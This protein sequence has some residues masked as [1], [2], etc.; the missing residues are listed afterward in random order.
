MFGEFKVTRKRSDKYLGQVL[1]E[2]GL[3]R[4]VEATIEERASKIKGAIYTT[5]S[6]LNTI[7]M[8]AMG[9]L[10]AAK[11][12]WEG[13]IVPS[14]LAGAGTWVGIPP[15]EEQMCEELQELYW[16]TVFQVPKGTPKVMLRAETSSLKMKFR[17]WREKL[18]SRWP[19]AGRV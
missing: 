9:G 5:A 4:S 12:L 13:A 1:H 18:R 6:I 15:K 10:M 3:A 14:L 2:G 8:Q 7:E 17:I 16:R 19:W 11:H